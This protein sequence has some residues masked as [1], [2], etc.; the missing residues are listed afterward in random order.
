MARPHGPPDLNVKHHPKGP[1]WIA[2]TG[3]P[4]RG[5]PGFRCAW[6]AARSAYDPLPDPAARCSV[7]D[8]DPGGLAGTRQHL[9]GP[10]RDLCTSLGH[11]LASLFF[12]TRPH[13][14]CGPRETGSAL[15]V[16]RPSSPPST[17]AP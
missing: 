9:V 1:A 6:P 13:P 5:N 16:S 12:F 8:D 2:D 11:F 3:S 7:A 4:D 10:G 14:A 17:T 15:R